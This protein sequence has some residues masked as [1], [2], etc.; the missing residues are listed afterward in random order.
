MFSGRSV[1]ASGSSRPVVPVKGWI[2]APV[3]DISGHED[4]DDTPSISYFPDGKRIVSGSRDRTIRE[5]DIEQGREIK[6]ARDVCERQVYTVR[7]SRD[8]RWVVSAGGNFMISGEL[9]V[10]EVETGTVR[11]FEGHRL[12]LTSI[13]CIDISG[14]ST[15]LASGSSDGTIRIWSLETCNLVAGPFRSLNWVVGAVRFSQDSKK[16]TLKSNGGRCLEV[17]DIQS[18][19]LLVYREGYWEPGDVPA[20]WTTKDTDIVTAFSFEVGAQIKTIYAFDASTLETTGAPFAGHTKIITSIALSLDCA[21]LA[22]AAR[23]N[24]I[25]FWAFESRQLLASFDSG[26][27]ICQLILS[28][29]LCQ[30]VCTT[31]NDNSIYL[32]DTPPE[33][34]ACIQPVPQD[35]TISSRSLF[36]TD[37]L[38][39]PF[40]F[41]PLH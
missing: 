24:T 16:L 27:T 13:N 12:V 26:S 11:T 7:V 15:L 10:R 30:L 33:I 39:P 34:L 5:W 4:R 3:L 22:S 9:K 21:L 8:G 38:I 19:K 36:L 14:D 28:P 6:R 1:T 18:Q 32:Y 20:F 35:R 17:W 25:N 23:D 37:V 29:N 41:I 2:L 31:E 40:S